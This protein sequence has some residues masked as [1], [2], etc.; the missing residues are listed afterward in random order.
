[1]T[2]Y[3]ETRGAG[4]HLVLLHGWGMHSGIWGDFAERLAR[5][6]RITCVDLPGHGR[7]TDVLDVYDLEH[8]A[9]AVV[10]KLDGAVHVLGWSLGGMIAQHLAFT[11]P[12]KVKSLVL[13]AASP[14]FTSSEDWPHATPRSTL[15]Q[16]ARELQDDYRATLN[17]FLALEVQ[18]SET[19]RDE[20][21]LLRQRVF[22]CGEPQFDAL[23]GGLDV[24]RKDNLR[25]SYAASNV[26]RLVILGRRDGLVPAGVS[27]DLVALH[28]ETRIHVVEGAAHAPFLTRP[29][30][31][32]TVIQEFLQ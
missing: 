31:C 15:E 27:N 14:Q 7:S 9:P 19:A 13:I 5:H 10:D 30:E 21:R 12:E 32:A 29:D 8:L 18:S 20:L 3:T 6:Y 1:M 25:A 24:L 2:L 11:R 28:P 23:R 17:R 4:A 22:A 16:F 26:R